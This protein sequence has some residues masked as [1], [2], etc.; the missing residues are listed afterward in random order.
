MSVKITVEEAPVSIR[1]L[2]NGDVEYELPESAHLDT[3]QKV[4]RVE[5]LDGLTYDIV[6]WDQEDSPA[7]DIPFSKAF[8]SR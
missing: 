4:R 8:P 7:F 5:E 1:F 6:A 3:K 2:G